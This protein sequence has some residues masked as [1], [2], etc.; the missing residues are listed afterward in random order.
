MSEHRH[1][2][3]DHEVWGDDP[4]ERDADAVVAELEVIDPA[5]ARRWHEHPAFVPFKAIGRFIQRSGKRIAVTIAGAVVILVG[6]AMLVLPGPGWVVIFAGLAILSTEYVWARRLLEKAK[7]K[8][9]QA[10]DAVF[11]KKNGGDP[12][13][14]V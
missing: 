1:L 9:G 5:A 3:H 13:P 4:E 8:A 14:D 12:P 2:P 7:E 10:K 11:R 6:V